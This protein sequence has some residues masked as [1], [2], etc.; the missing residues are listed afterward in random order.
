[1]NTIKIENTNHRISLNPV[2]IKAVAEGTS[3]LRRGH[4]VF[5]LLGM[6]QNEIY[7]HKYL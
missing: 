5:Y 3:A 6:T 2:F 4:G 7:A 1:M